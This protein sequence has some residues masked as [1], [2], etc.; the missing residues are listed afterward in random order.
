M[1]SE[2]NWNIEQL[3]GIFM[4]LWFRHNTVCVKSVKVFL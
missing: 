4:S 2:L 3:K 1:H